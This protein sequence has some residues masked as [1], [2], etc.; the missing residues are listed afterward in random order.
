MVIR[1]KFL[2][3]HGCVVTRRVAYGKRTQ[4]F[5]PPNGVLKVSEAVAALGTND[6][7]LYRLARA[8]KL[9]VRRIGGEQHFPLAE[10]KRLM[11]NRRALYPGR[12]GAA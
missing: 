10:V 9:K 12:R 4:R 8:G 7:R 11:R 6:M 1:V 5:V 2:K 3:N